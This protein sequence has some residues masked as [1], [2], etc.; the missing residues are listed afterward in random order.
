MFIGTVVGI[1]F[2]KE[3]QINLR[4]KMYYLIQI[5][6]LR[7]NSMFSCNYPTSLRLMVSKPLVAVYAGIRKVER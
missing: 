7:F 1:N 2:Y 4:N 6:S 3:I 5:I